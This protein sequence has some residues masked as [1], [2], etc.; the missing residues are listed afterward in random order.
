MKRN[1]D[2]IR[3]L[4]QA[5]EAGTMPEPLLA[6]DKSELIVGHLQLL[7]DAGFLDGRPYDL[8]NNVVIEATRLTWAGHE[9]IA[10]SR[11]STT[12]NKAK[13]LIA[14]KGLDLS[15]EGLKFVLTDVLPPLIRSALRG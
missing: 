6:E 1:M 11:S 14:E 8:S 4:L 13:A 5:V 15:A 7:E 12:W 9:F 10:L 2:L 3:D